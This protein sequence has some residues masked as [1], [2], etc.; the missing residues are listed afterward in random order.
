M[1]GRY[2]SGGVDD[3]LKGVIF[4]TIPVGSGSVP[5]QL[6]FLPSSF[7]EAIFRQVETLLVMDHRVP[8]VKWEML[9]VLKLYAG[10]PQDILDARQ[11]LKVRQPSRAELQAVG[12]LATTLGVHEAWA[13]LSAGLLKNHK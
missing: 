12:T 3:P 6:I 10:G 7:T 11:I 1:G 13:T 4:A 2:E 5:L 9:V 8:V